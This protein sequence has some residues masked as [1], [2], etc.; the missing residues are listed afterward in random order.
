MI[1][2]YRGY[3]NKT[4]GDGVMA[5]FGVPFESATHQTDAV[6]A[7][8]AM[9]QEIRD[10]FPF[11]MRIGINAGTVT[12]G[13]LGPCDKSL[14][15]V[16]GDAVNIASRMEA[17]S[18]VGGIAV[19]QATRDVL[20]PWFAFESLGDQDVG[21][22]ACFN[23]QG[24]RGLTDD[25]RRVDPTSRFATD[26]EAVIDEVE[27]HKRERLTMIDFIS[28]QARDAALLHNDAVASF[29]LALLWLLRSDVSGEGLWDGVDEQALVAAARLHDVGKHALEPA[30]LNDAALDS[31]GRDVLR[32]DL[33]DKTLATIE[34][35]GEG[36]LAP[37]IE[38]LYRFEATRGADGA[39]APEVEILAA[40]DINDTL[41]A[42]KAYKGAPWRIVGALDELQRLPYC[43]GQQRP[44]FDAFVALMKPK[45]ATVSVRARADVLIR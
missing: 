35:V 40:A 43:Q 9:Q 16:L 36:A 19:S 21:A 5:L 41:T 42:P 45:D 1:G 8:L 7:A 15:D 3:V 25:A 34:Q 13:M 28:L 12:A 32:R 33:R 44:V 38:D 39:Y 11:D 18:S 20:A 26:H 4:N 29:A 23:V 10:R 24:L 30:R 6:L 14:Y 22:M 2:R 27:A 37:V 31:D 17:L